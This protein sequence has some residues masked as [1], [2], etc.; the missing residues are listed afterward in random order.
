MVK[1]V[2]VPETGGMYRVETRKGEVVIRRLVEGDWV[3]EVT[4]ACGDWQEAF[5][6]HLEGQG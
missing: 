4:K 3:V 6:E 1:V 5:R 2:R